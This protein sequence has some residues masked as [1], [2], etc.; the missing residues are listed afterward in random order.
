MGFYCNSN[1]LEKEKSK[2]GSRH[3]LSSWLVSHDDTEVQKTVGYCG[4]V[5]HCLG[6]Q[7]AAFEASK[8]CPNWDS[9]ESRQWRLFQVRTP[10]SFKKT[11]SQVEGAH[12]CQL[13]IALH[14]KYRKNRR[15]QLFDLLLNC[16]TRRVL[17]QEAVLTARRYRKHAILSIPLILFHEYIF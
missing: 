11:P 10:I 2:R 12:L 7:C 1:I 16:A 13:W 6:L 8:I 3:G 15:S 5:P 17:K 4:W 9:R 14:F